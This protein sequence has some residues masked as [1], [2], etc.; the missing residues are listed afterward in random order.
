MPKLVLIVLLALAYFWWSGDKA[1]VKVPDSDISF[2]YIVRYSG[3]AS[4]SDELPMV[5]ALHGNGDTAGNF[6]KTALNEIEAD[7]R[8]IIFKAPIPM[9]TGGAW[10]MEAG[11]LDRYAEALTDAVDIVYEEYPTF[12]DPLV[13][14][15][16]GGGV[17]S[18]YLAAA[19][20][21]SYSYIFPVSGML[22]KD[23]LDGLSTEGSKTVEVL[24]FH[25]KNDR[26][27][28]ISGGRRA[29]ELLRER[30]IKIDFQEFEGNHHG[31]FTNMKEEISDLISEKI[32]E[33]Y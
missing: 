2:D 19:F 7:A 25:G 4:K 31:L 24:A 9:G 22:K 32:R 1:T 30:G 17:M 10:P 8:I 11:E 23:S 28:K 14:G 18:Y 26:V 29:T 20:P 12:G 27:V 13:V 21:D 6:Y 3:D 33:S 5:V 16:S 15:F